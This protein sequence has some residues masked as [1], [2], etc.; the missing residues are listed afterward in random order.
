MLHVSRS[1]ELLAVDGTSSALRVTSTAVNS[2]YPAML[3]SYRDHIERRTGYDD[4][5]CIRT[6]HGT[7]R[8]CRVGDS[9]DEKSLCSRSR[10]SLCSIM[11]VCPSP[12]ICCKA[13]GSM[14]RRRTHTTSRR[15]VIVIHGDA[16]AREF[17]Q[18]VPR[19]RYAE[20]LSSKLLR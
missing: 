17:T 18:H 4:A 9:E 1:T 14:H 2:F 7:V 6:W 11:E 12:C 13:Q 20:T 3:T 10:C 15:L 19:P 5:N 8:V 16:S